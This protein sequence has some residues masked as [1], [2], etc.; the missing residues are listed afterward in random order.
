MAIAPLSVQ[1]PTVSLIGGQQLA[2]ASG[3]GV[4]APDISNSFAQ[5][6]ATLQSQAE[7]NRT[8]DDQ[9]AG[10]A[11][12][13]TFMNEHPGKGPDGLYTVMPHIEGSAPF[14]L[15]ALDT[16]E[17]NTMSKL[18]A[19]ANTKFGEY[20][21]NLD[22]T[23]AQKLA[24]MESYSS[25]IIE[26]LPP[27]LRPAART[28]FQTEIR[29]RQ[30]QMVG[31]EYERSQR[32]MFTGLQTR[33]DDAM[34]L[35]VSAASTGADYTR[36]TQEAYKVLD[37][38]VG[39]HLIDQVTADSIKMKAGRLVVAAGTQD[40][41]AREAF[42]GNITL[43]NLADFALAVKTGGSVDL[44]IHRRFDPGNVKLTAEEREA[45]G[46]AKT[47][48]PAR[49]DV[50]VINSEKMREQLGTDE[51]RNAVSADLYQLAGHLLADYKADEKRRGFANWMGAQAPGSTDPVPPAYHSTEDEIVSEMLAQRYFDLPQGREALRQ[52]VLHGKRM[53]P[54]LLAVMK[55]RLYGSEEQAR[56][57]L[58][59]WNAIDSAQ[60]GGNDVG[61]MV[62]ATMEASDVMLFERAQALIQ[63]TASPEQWRQMMGALKDPKNTID[64][65]KEQFNEAS[66]K[67]GWLTFDRQL[68][69]DIQR[70]YGRD[71][72][73][74]QIQAE[75]ER[76]FWAT[77]SLTQN[78]SVIE[79][80]K[81][82]WEK[83]KTRWTQDDAFTPGYARHPPFHN[84]PGY[85]DNTLFLPKNRWTNDFLKEQLDHH[86]RA[87][88]IYDPNGDIK[89]QLDRLMSASL[90][91]GM[92]LGNGVTLNPIEGNLDEGTQF[93]VMLRM[94]DGTNQRIMVTGPDGRA[95]PL[96]VD[97]GVVLG[98]IES[99]AEAGEALRS[100][101][102]DAY[103]ARTAQ[104]WTEYLS[105]LSPLDRLGHSFDPNPADWKADD[106]A[107]WF[108]KRPDEFQKKYVKDEASR[109]E[110][111]RKRAK[112]FQE[113]EVPIPEGVYVNPQLMNEANA[114]GYGVTVGAIRQIEQVFP[115]GTGGQFMLNLA[116]IESDM[117][118]A[119]GTFRAKGD[120]GIWQINDGPKGAFAEIQRRAR[121]VGDPLQVANQ[122]AIRAFGIDVTNLSPSDLNRPIVS[123]LL[124]RM[125]FL[126][127][128]NQ[129]PK[130]TEG[131][132]HL[133][134]SYY[135]TY[136]GKGSVGGF[137]SRA[138]SVLM[139]P[140]P[141]TLATLEPGSPGMITDR[142]GNRDPANF[143]A[144]DQRTQ[145]SAYQ[146]SAAF[147]QALQITP[148]GGTQPD[149]RS[150]TSQHHTGTAIDIWVGDMPPSERTRLIAL[151]I[152][153]GYRGVGG[154]GA[155]D[156]KNTIHLDLRGDGLTT[157]IAKWWRHVP[158]VDG[159]WATGEKWF[160]DGITQGALQAGLSLG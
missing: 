123:A 158:G 100:M 122:R 66:T 61:T 15:S 156:G 91:G 65:W 45:P 69:Q 153:M 143:L 51:L 144:T 145:I 96:L 121:I 119:A 3:E 57:A 104:L 109:Q 120:R 58:E 141:A 25:G 83:I 64:H 99:R 38:Q 89:P 72:V 115:D 56:D 43:E 10:P 27:N 18:Q 33:F 118:R 131:Q 116:L 24:K 142:D 134:K 21:S 63:E 29:Q 7:R 138:N 80:Y 112:E 44:V 107:R 28:Y 52:T 114:G 127:L 14:R 70:W 140:T 135:N 26:T 36:H 160:V 154:Y 87:G 20:Q 54:P 84:P 34:T 79:A 50:A 53:P 124:A 5:F 13:E 117:G 60:D 68:Q 4:R 71:N 82:S 136:L 92:M 101:R 62:R 108:A 39:L 102:D 48:P 41:V 151:A 78:P 11:A 147:G 6:A 9:I 67:A 32:A 22:E 47:E 40:M 146:L 88:T 130:D 16:L 152:R 148:H 133:W 8:I 105:D 49:G 125:Y 128:P 139:P 17:R 85:L 86:I 19:S 90:A 73:S 132:A 23:V 31:A 46:P 77:M 74:P 42:N 98:I 110:A 150:S 97:P 129:I 76:T 113:K 137:M 55:N 157:H 103:L 106:F 94:Q 93:E 126:R 35:A 159:N 111:Y 59:F 30:D 12:M 149:D 95:V 81:A 1:R 155:G 37:E 75:M 2:K